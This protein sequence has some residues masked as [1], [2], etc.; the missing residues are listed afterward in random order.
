MSDKTLE[1]IMKTC[2]HFI[3]SR[4]ERG[5]LLLQT[6]NSIV[7]IKYVFRNLNNNNYSLLC[8]DSDAIQLLWNNFISARPGAIVK[9]AFISVSKGN[10]LIP[11]FASS[12]IQVESCPISREFYLHKLSSLFLIILIW[13]GIVHV[14]Q[15]YSWKIPLKCLC[16]R[17]QLEQ[18][19]WLKKQIGNYKVE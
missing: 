11:S 9:L 2:L 15:N 17:K 8:I 14:L 13:H 7:I 19:E 6:H 18:C 5:K 12:T 10:K 3:K 4:L 16:S 1:F